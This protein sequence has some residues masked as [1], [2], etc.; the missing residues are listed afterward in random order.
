MTNLVLKYQFSASRPAHQIIF[1]DFSYAFNT[2]QPNVLIGRL[3]EQFKLSYTVLGWI[4]DFLTNR[5]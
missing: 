3:L 1:V 5:T 4:L 2:I